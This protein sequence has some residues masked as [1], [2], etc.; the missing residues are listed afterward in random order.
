MGPV[1]DLQGVG[2]GIALLELVLSAYL[3]IALFWHFS[4]TGSIFGER[5]W[6]G[7]LGTVLDC[8]A[9]VYHLLYVY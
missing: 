2:F 6:D 1:L 3:W 9:G 5:H 4:G 8:I 7:H